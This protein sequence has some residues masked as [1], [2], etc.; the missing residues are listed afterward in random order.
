VATFNLVMYPT[1]LY[2]G[3]THVATFNLV[4][5]PTDLYKG[6]TG[7]KK[8]SAFMKFAALSSILGHVNTT[9]SGLPVIRAAK[10]EESFRIQ[11]VKLQDT[12][13]SLFFTYLAA[14][15]W[16]LLSMELISDC[17]ISIL[18]LYFILLSSSK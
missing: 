15:R 8:I 2:K 17:C 3:R 1:D 18:L 16:L 14:M 11:L 9:V 10:A 4:M 13:T 7:F 12:H 6:I 5:Y